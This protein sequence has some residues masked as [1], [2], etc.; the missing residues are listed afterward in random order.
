M[1][2]TE[3]PLL[4][5]YI[6]RLDAALASVPAEERR[7]IID[8]VSEHAAAA[9]AEVAA[10]TETDVR[11][12]LTRLGDPE[13]IATEARDRL[14]ITTS[15]NGRLVTSLLW[16]GIAIGVFDLIAVSTSQVGPVEFTFLAVPVVILIAVAFGLRRQANPLG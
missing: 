10:P 2:T 16:I 3:H 12:I 6:A 1:T 7:E 8:G 11:N 4:Q 9:L 14:G 15:R 13:A 5:S